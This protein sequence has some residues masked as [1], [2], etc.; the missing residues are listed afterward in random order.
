MNCK[1]CDDSQ[2]RTLRQGS[3]I[4]VY[5]SLSLPLIRRVTLSN[6]HSVKQ[7]TSSNKRGKGGGGGER[8]KKGKTGEN[9]RDVE[10]TRSPTVNEK[11]LR[12][13]GSWRARNH[14]NKIPR[15]KRNEKQRLSSA[16]EL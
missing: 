1:P 14:D 4:T 9:T 6:M 3:T 16:P 15:K 12:H 10:V 8:V 7:Q 2:R 11:T 13:L 5:T